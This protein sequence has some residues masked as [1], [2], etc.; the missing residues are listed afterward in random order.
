MPPFPM[1]GVDWMSAKQDRAAPRTVADIERKYNFGKSFAAVMGIAEDTR[2]EVDAAM[3]ELS[4]KTK[5]SE[6]WRTTD[7]IGAK[8][9]ETGD[10]VQSIEAKVTAQ[11]LSITAV[12]KE[13]EDGVEKVK[14]K[15]GYVFDSE[16]LKISKD[17][18]SLENLIDNTGMKV[19]WNNDDVLV[20]NDKGV[21]AKDLHARTY[22]KIG[23][24][25]GRCR[26]EDYGLN[27]IGCFW[28]G[29]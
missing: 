9:T 21:T 6:L 19:T 15:T 11:E 20:A 28:T 8:V 7:E 13:L 5:T 1:N 17:G 29:G 18:E 26:F 16:G 25:N 23:S 12:E 24:G 2:D 27:R 3:S 4:G 10:K 22:L 14:T